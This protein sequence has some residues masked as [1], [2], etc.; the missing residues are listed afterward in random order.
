MNLSFRS[1]LLA[2]VALV[3]SSAIVAARVERHLDDIRRHYLPK[4]GLRPRLEA[5]FERIQRGFQDAVAA[6]DNEKLAGTAALKKEL[7]QQLADSSEAVDPALAAALEQ[8]VEEFHAKGLAVSAR[9]IARETG[10]GVVAQIGEL[11][12]KQ[13]RVA[14]L[15]DKAT[16]FD[17]S[18]LTNAFSAAAEAQRTGSRVRL[19]LSVACLVV[20]LLLS[21]WISREM[22]DGVA[23]LTAGFRRFGEGDFRSAIPVTTRDELGEVARQANHMAQSLHRLELERGRVDWLKSGQSA[24]SEQL[25]GELEPKEVADRAVSTLCRSLD[26]PVGAL[27]AADADGVFRLLGQYALSAGEGALEFRSGEGL[28]GQAT[29]QSE[30]MVVD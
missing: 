11:Q 25:R 24:L 20:V 12:A 7:L 1:K 27:Y 3:V 6:S 23:H 17:K 26:C 16:V 14:E 30:I 9:L 22:L 29:L 28:V 8:A 19:G 15:L 18:E 4:V 21:L 5:Q 2:L 13:T 10:E